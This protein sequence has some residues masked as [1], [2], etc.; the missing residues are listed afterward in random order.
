MGFCLFNNVAVA[1]ARALAEGGLDRVT[2][3]D[4]DVHHGNGTQEIFWREPGVQYVSLHRDRFYPGTGHADETG[5][6]EGKGSTLNVPL[7]GSTRPKA[8]REAFTKTMDQVRA[9]KPQLVIASAG[10]DAYRDDPIGGLGLSEDDYR[11]IGEQLR[12][13]AD[14]QAAGRLI[15]AL[16]G[17][18]AVD[19]L[20]GLVRAYLEGVAGAASA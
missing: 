12:S 2:I 4:F 20:G 10:F 17:G 8:Y 11:F 9:F 18:Y 5:E 7:P 1:A 13:V 19:A 15:S 3:V 14:D 6:G 16:E